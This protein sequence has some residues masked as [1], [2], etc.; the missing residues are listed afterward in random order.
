MILDLNKSCDGFSLINKAGLILS[1]NG[2][3]KESKNIHQEVTI[4]GYMIFRTVV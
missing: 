1:S 3:K 4:Y 2:L